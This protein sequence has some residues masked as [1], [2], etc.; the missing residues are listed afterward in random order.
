MRQAG[1][2]RPKIINMSKYQFLNIVTAVNVLVALGFAIAGVLNPA[3]IVPSHN[4]NDPAAEVFAL[5]AVARAI[6]IALLTI[7]A[8]F[9]KNGQQQVVTLAILA[10]FIQTIDGCI[11]IYLKEP[12]KTIGPFILAALAFF[13]VFMVRKCETQ[14]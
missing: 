10:G 2:L 3:L 8:V 5:Y 9:Q 6:P 14:R 12:S 4:G 11:G 13:A 7:I 1:Q